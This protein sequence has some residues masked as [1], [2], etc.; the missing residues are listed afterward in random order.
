MNLNVLT[1]TSSSF[2]P[3]KVVSLNRVYGSLEFRCDE[4][5]VLI[6]LCYLVAYQLKLGFKSG[7]LKFEHKVVLTSHG[8]QQNSIDLSRFFK[9]LSI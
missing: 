8:G 6:L 4:D 5:L 7:A 2:E 3:N 9:I 1:T